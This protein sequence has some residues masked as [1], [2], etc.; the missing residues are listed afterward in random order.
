MCSCGPLYTSQF[1]FRAENQTESVDMIVIAP[2]R[3]IF[4][5][6][7]N[8]PRTPSDL[9]A[10]LEMSRYAKIDHDRAIKRNINTT[11]NLVQML[12]LVDL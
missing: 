7:I 4:L 1:S 8:H 11:I 9:S 5:S 6:P 2:R 3:E 10:W 12:P